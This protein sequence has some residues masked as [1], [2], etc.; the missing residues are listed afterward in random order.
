MTE[1]GHFRGRV[2]G[3]PGVPDGKWIVT[4][5]VAPEKRDFPAATIWTETGSAYR[6]GAPK[7]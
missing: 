7:Q 6:L 2:H 1:A 4:S 5:F 3:K